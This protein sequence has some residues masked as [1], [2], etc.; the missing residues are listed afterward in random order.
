MPKPI[1][2][3]VACSENRVIGKNGAL[4]WRI[5]EDTEWFHKKTAGCI[6]I[7]GRICFETWPQATG[8]DRQVIVI[9]QNTSLAK[10]GV[11]IVPGVAQALA[12][13][14]TLEG[15]IMVC[16]GQRIYEET[17]PLAHRLYLTLVHATVEGDTYFPD[18]EA[19]TWQKIEHREGND[20]HHRYT[21]QVLE[22]V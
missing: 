1:S 15:E 5:P 3:I 19:Y 11:H 10:P 7:L 16:G 18:W 20:A 2:L 4:P 22:R 9:S 17:L 6:I 12:L 13:A 8:E 14:E 21:F